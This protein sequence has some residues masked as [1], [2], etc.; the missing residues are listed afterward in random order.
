[1]HLQS[2]GITNTPFHKHEQT[3]T[4]PE[5][6][7]VV[8]SLISLLLQ[9]R[10]HYERTLSEA[11]IV[12]LNV[13][14]SAMEQSVLSTTAAT[15]AVHE[16]L[17][18]LWHREWQSPS[19]EFDIPDPTIRTLALRSLKEDGSFKDPSAVTPDIAKF[20]YL[21]RLSAVQEIRTL[22]R[23]KYNGNQH[24]AANDVLPWLQEKF[25]SPFNSLMSLQ[26]RATSI[27]YNTPSLP[28]TWWMDTD[29]WSH[30]LYKGYSVKMDDIANVFDQLEKQSISQFEEKVL[31]G[32]KIK[33]EYTRL[34][35]NLR[36][37]EVGYSFLTDPQ[38]Q[39]TFG[40]RDRFINAVL[41]DP[42]LRAQFFITHADGSMSYN[43]HA[44]RAWLHEYGLH[45]ANMLMSCEMKAGAPGRLTELWNM[46]FGNTP[47]RTRNM[48]MQGFF[49]VLNRKYT[50]T[51]NISGYDKLIPH[52][53][54]ALTAD[55]LI[56][57]LAIARPFAELAIQICF[58]DDEEK[59]DL[60][61][62]NLFVANAKAFDTATI[63]DHM[64]RLTRPICSFQIGVRD[65][66]Q[67]H[68]AFAR[69]HCGQAE[70]LM[71]MGE[72]DTA[73]IR[74][75]GHGRSVHD[76]I[77][78]RSANSIDKCALPEDI[79]PL[80]LEASTEWQIKTLTVPGKHLSQ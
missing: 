17:I 78:G 19:S 31:L 77:Y 24:K 55:M 65:W 7:A 46:C 50:K 52:A 29:D 72:E 63:T 13:F 1:M 76:G 21:M 2:S 3:T 15:V 69:K 44:W 41:A 43:K 34:A 57:D 54:D 71:E 49:T 25:V 45:S 12:A 35:D 53:L 5:Y 16:L 80:Y 64:H 40:N 10:N 66:R 28:N 14:E 62:Y 32:L 38:N 33:V 61:R 6:C 42:E 68:A 67:I 23:V 59:K 39:D 48:V 56:Q 20:E 30:M 51:G 75:F 37:T 27:V 47:M 36:S 4:L 22:A 9:D 74:Q 26:H 70:Q 8:T 11:T 18:K 79:L 73:Q 60:Y 58:P